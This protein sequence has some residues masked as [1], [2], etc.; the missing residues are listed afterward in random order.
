MKLLSKAPPA[1]LPVGSIYINASASTN[2][3]TLLGYGTWVAFGSGRVLVGHDSGDADFNTAEKVGGAKTHTLTINEL[4]KIWADGN[5]VG[6]RPGNAGFN[7]GS[8]SGFEAGSSAVT[9]TNG[10]DEAH[11][12]LQPYITVHMWKRVA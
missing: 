4:P 12:N 1:R 5:V 8:G 7:T 2:P 11:N 6:V 9:L 10:G 3:A